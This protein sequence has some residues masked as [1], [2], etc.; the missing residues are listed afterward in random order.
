M[1]CP[2]CKLSNVIVDVE[3]ILVEKYI[4]QKNGKIKKLKLL[5]NHQE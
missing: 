2:K 4:I 3:Y 1:R 5:K